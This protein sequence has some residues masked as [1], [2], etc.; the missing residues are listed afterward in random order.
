MSRIKFEQGDLTE[1]LRNQDISVED[2]VECLED[3]IHERGR[4]V[5][6]LPNENP[7]V[8]LKLLDDFKRAYR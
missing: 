7:A 5:T 1:A 3:V 8:L 4:Q 6:M 2:V